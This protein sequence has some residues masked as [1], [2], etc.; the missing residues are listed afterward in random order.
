MSKFNNIKKNVKQ[1]ERPVKITSGTN[2]GRKETR[3]G[4]E[5]Q[6]GLI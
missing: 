5:Q 1:L 4:N 6:K 3:N 2:N